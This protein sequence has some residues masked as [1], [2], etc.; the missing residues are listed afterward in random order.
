M[1]KLT[2]A[3]VVGERLRSRREAKQWRQEDVAR[4]M[5]EDNLHPWDR[6]TVASV[7]AGA[8]S[9]T[10]TESAALCAVFH[11]SWVEFLELD[12]D[13]PS[14]EVE[15]VYAHRLLIEGQ[16]LDPHDVAVETSPGV[17][18]RWPL[19][20]EALRGDGTYLAAG[21]VGGPG[22]IRPDETDRKAARSLGVAAED[23]RRAAT[24]LWGRSLAA[25]RDK[26]LDE[27]P[28]SRSPRSLQAHRGHVTRMLLGE[29]RAQLANEASTPSAKKGRRP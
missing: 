12:D 5:R 25:E 22:P 15:G 21:A 27:S 26:R 28:L 9:L 13:D 3:Q 16:L 7:E 8:R 1:L 23:V 10:A 11:K 17:H 4:R 18:V 2:S 14:E 29:L 24:T 19:I 6:V 20:I